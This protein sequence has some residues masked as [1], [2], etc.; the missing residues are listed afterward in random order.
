MLRILTD[1]RRN[2]MPIAMRRAES[3]HLATPEELGNTALVLTSDDSAYV[4]GIELDV[5]VDGGVAQF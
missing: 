4:T 3:R 1:A 2:A 5:D